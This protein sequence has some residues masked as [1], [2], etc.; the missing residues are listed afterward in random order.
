MEALASL[1]APPLNRLRELLWTITPRA[2]DAE[3]PDC[4]DANSD[5]M[6][7]V[8]GGGVIVSA[9]IYM[10]LPSEWCPTNPSRCPDRLNL[11][12]A[13]G[14]VA[15]AGPA[16]SGHVQFLPV[17][18]ASPVF[19]SASCCGDGRASPIDRHAPPGCVGNH[20]SRA[21]SGDDGR[22]APRDGIER[23][24]Q[25]VGYQPMLEIQL[26]TQCGVF[27]S[28]QSQAQARYW[29]E[30]RALTLPQLAAAE[31]RAM[32]ARP[33]VARPDKKPPLH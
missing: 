17:S 26:A 23:A 2:T 6:T 29:I 5:E 10:P 15:V 27:A 8:A 4:P 28:I 19:A 31:Y 7:A 11:A 16:R 18:C 33:S 25:S 14:P 1:L 13:T 20:D 12:Q 22:T 21:V 3:P 32:N 24:A 9:T 30:R